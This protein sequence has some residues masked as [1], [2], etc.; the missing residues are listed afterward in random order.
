MKP[1][2]YRSSFA[3]KPIRSNFLYFWASFSDI[4]KR[5]AKLTYIANRYRTAVFLALTDNSDLACAPAEYMRPT[6]RRQ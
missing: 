2:Y 5:R 4:V 6:Q 1:T 3:K